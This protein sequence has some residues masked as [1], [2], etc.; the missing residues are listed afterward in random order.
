[1]NKELEESTYIFT[2]SNSQFY[3]NISLDFLKYHTKVKP[4]RSLLLFFRS[5]GT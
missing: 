3:N 4:T 1:M 5:H 2:Q